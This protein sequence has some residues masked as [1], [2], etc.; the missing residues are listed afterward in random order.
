MRK[1]DLGAAIALIL[2][3]IAGVAQFSSFATRLEEIDRKLEKP[4]EIMRQES[5]QIIKEMHELLE[6]VA[7]QNKSGLP[8][9]T[10]VASTLD[11]KGFYKLV[12]GK[13]PKTTNE[14][15]EITT[16]EWA[17][18]DGRVV[19]G[20]KYS[21]LIN[22]TIPDL[23]GVFLRG[24]NIF[25]DD[26]NEPNPHPDP[27]I[28]RKPGAYQPQLIK[29]HSH[30]LGTYGHDGDGAENKWNFSASNYTRIEEDRHTA[31][32]GVGLGI[33]TRPNNVAVNFY[34]KIN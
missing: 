20:T 8:V 26:K 19:T 24:T 2:A 29:E 3:I 9:G 27:D 10:I 33:E 12:E 11:Y 15:Y 32:K 5:K 28:D 6:K 1:I 25:S 30:S 22:P 7:I 17:P 21:E 31:I 18:A 13:E 34:I 14:K 16:A 4:V 23:R